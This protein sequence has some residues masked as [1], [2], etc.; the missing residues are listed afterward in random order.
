M[1]MI[2]VVT[3]DTVT[4]ECTT[5]PQMNRNELDAKR[6]W[7]LAIAQIN[8]NNPNN[9]P[10]KDYQL[11][12]IGTFDTETLVIEPCIEFLANAQEFIKE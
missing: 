7:G 11:F 6:S 9:I 4:G 12:K 8:A 1:K 5:A 2:L 10:I 3:K